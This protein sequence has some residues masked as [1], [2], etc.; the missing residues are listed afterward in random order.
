MIY[1]TDFT[2]PKTTNKTYLKASKASKAPRKLKALIALLKHAKMAT[3]KDALVYLT[4]KDFDPS[5]LTFSEVKEN[6]VG[7]GKSFTILYG[8]SKFCVKTPDMRTSF[9]A[10]QPKQ[11]DTKPIPINKWQLQLSFE[12]NSPFHVM[13]EQFDSA[14]VAAANIP[15]NRADWLG[16]PKNKEINKEV[17]DE[18]FAL[19]RTVKR[20]VDKNTKIV[21]T[22]Y[23]PYL[24]ANFNI[25]LPSDKYASIKF[26]TTI[27]QDRQTVEPSLDQRDTNYMKNIIPPR[28]IVRSVLRPLGW[29]SSNGFGIKW[30]IEVMNVSPA[31]NSHPANILYDDE[32]DADVS[33]S[34]KSASTVSKITNG[35]STVKLDEED[36]LDSADEEEA[37]DDV[38]ASTTKT[39]APP[40]AD[41]DEDDEDAHAEEEEKQRPKTPPPVVGKKAP[42][43]RRKL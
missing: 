24:T 43:R 4:P 36:D 15:N 26:G 14:V 11:T 1:Y 13:M 10:S 8:G 25:F 6:K 16:K 31:L 2:T 17:I 28:S 29:V 7:Q 39:S 30:Y 42:L 19:G 5:K 27:T 35:I 23:P 37:D 3:Q 34:G 9:G 22:D 20:S 32:D 12:E 21:K 18:K 40:V 38:V 41:D 33:V